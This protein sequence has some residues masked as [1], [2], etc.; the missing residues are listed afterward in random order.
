MANEIPLRNGGFPFVSGL[1]V[2][3]TSR[4]WTYNLASGAD[5]VLQENGTEV[6]RY[7]GGDDTWYFYSATDAGGV[8]VS[9]T[10]GGTNERCITAQ[11][12]SATPGT[13]D[14]YL[15]CRDSGGGLDGYFRA[16]GSGGIDTVHSSD[17]RG[18][19]NVADAAAVK[20]KGRAIVRAIRNRQWQHADNPNPD[21]PLGL[22]WVAQELLE[23]FPEAVHVP[24]PDNPD[25]GLGVMPMKLIPLLVEAVQELD[26]EIADLRARIEALEAR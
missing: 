25:Q 12:G 5:W 2:D 21:A 20:G 19:R 9:S 7:D 11:L 1:T 4:Q 6:G 14:Y 24:S 15:A 8:W 26:A 10:A 3:D 23:A 17:I 16:D 18:K 22:G 13:D